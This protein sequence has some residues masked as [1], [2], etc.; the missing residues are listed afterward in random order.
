ML[1]LPTAKDNLVRYID[2]GFL[3]LYIYTYEEEKADRYILAATGRRK[4]LE[5][6]GADGYVNFETKVFFS[7]NM[8]LEA[9][10]S[11]LNNGKE[12]DR[13]LLVIK[14]ADNQLASR[15]LGLV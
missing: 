14:D 5:W 13:K 10:L 1:H 8:S 2:A 12:L 6:N 9:T 3:I 15:E 11:L 4:I 7:S